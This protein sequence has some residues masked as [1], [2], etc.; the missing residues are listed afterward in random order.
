MFGGLRRFKRGNPSRC[1][2]H[3][4]YLLNKD[5]LFHQNLLHTALEW[6]SVKNMSACKKVSEAITGKN[7]PTDL[8]GTVFKFYLH[9]YTCTY[10][11]RHREC[12]LC[13]TPVSKVT[14]EPS[15]ISSLVELVKLLSLN[16]FVPSNLFTSTAFSGLLTS[17]A[18]FRSLFCGIGWVDPFF[19]FLT[20]FLRCPLQ[21]KPVAITCMTGSLHTHRTVGMPSIWWAWGEITTASSSSST[22]ERTNS[23][24]F[25]T[26][27][28]VWRARDT[29]AIAVYL[30]LCE[31]RSYVAC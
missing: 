12:I 29:A 26:R 17:L 2:L 28:D 7:S 18:C 14:G 16:R 21:V 11:L 10:V 4:E 19:G 30:F 1:F 25:R 22:P 5:S 6:D 31:L 8:N 24:T 27:Y 3:T 15:N 9:V 23:S 20:G 13:T